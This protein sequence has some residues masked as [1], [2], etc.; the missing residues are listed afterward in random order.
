ME[1]PVVKYINRN[2]GSMQVNIL[3]VQKIII[4]QGDVLI[5]M[6]WI[7]NILRLS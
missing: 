6:P 5:N 7:R 4:L 1:T 3:V 2:L